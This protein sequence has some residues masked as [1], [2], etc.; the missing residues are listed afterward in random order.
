M[1]EEKEYKKTFIAAGVGTAVVAVCCFT[2]VLVLLLGIV[3]LSAFTAVPRLCSLPCAGHSDDPGC[4]FLQ[5]MEKVPEIVSQRFAESPWGTVEIAQTIP[6]LYIWFPA[7][8]H[9]L[10]SIFPSSAYTLTRAGNNWM[11]EIMA[12]F[13][14]PDH[15]FT[16][17]SE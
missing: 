17:V 5:E 15:L 1:A 10:A 8:T 16:R 9:G 4:G 7:S 11:P 14:H 2:P 12:H 3:G 13:D 6:T